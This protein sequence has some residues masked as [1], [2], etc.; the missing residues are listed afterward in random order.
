M[1]DPRDCILARG[2]VCV[3]TIWEKGGEIKTAKFHVSLRVFVFFLFAFASAPTFE[4]EAS[5]LSLRRS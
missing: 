1:D 5:K 2:R 3:G 4:E